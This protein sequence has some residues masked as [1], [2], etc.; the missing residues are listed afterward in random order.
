VYWDRRISRKKWFDLKAEFR[1]LEHEELDLPE[2]ADSPD[3]G[4]EIEGDLE[5][6]V[7]TQNG[8]NLG[9]SEKGRWVKITHSMGKNYPLS[10]EKLPMP[11]YRKTPLLHKKEG[12]AI[13]LPVPR[14]EKKDMKK[15]LKSQGDLL[16]RKTQENREGIK[17]EKSLRQKSKPP[18]PRSL[19]KP[20]LKYSNSRMAEYLRNAYEEKYSNEDIPSSLFSSRK[21]LGQLKNLYKRIFAELSLTGAEDSEIDRE[22]EREMKKYIDFTFEH[23]EDL[24]AHFK[25]NSRLSPGLLLGFH[26]SFDLIMSGREV[27]PRRGS[28]S[29]NTGKATKSDPKN[30]PMEKILRDLSH[31]ERRAEANGDWTPVEAHKARYGLDSSS[32]G[33]S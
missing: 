23:W 30:Y 19:E 3:F 25:L 9:D 27:L 6:P 31:L 16:S 22:V 24:R 15:D 4:D 5:A 14:G 17:K 18:V 10:G 28:I 13:S 21:E 26:K 33:D 29:L 8:H 2:E 12:T 11:P 1:D 7:D 32:E 20:T